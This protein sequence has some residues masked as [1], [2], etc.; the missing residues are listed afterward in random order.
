MHSTPIYKD[1]ILV[2][3]GHSHAL[4]LRMW[5]MNPIPGVRITLVSNTVLSPYSGMLPGVIAGHYTLDDN[6]IDLIKLCR[7][8]GARFIHGEVTGFDL[9]QQR[10]QLRGRPALSFDYAS[11]NTGAAPDQSVPGVA[12]FATPIKPIA[13]FTQRWQVLLDEFKA[14]KGKKHI[15]VV[16]SGAGG[17]EVLL[18][19]QHALSKDVD[20]KA[21]LHF[22]LVVRGQGLLKG[23]SR[24]VKNSVKN[25][26]AKCG[27]QVH[28][29]FD[30]AELQETQLVSNNGISLAVDS[31]FW[32]TSAVAPAWPKAC[33]FTTDEQG[34]ISVTPYLQSMSNKNIFAAGDIAHM[35]HAPRPKAGVYAV[36]QAPILLHNLRNAVLKKPL[37]SYKPQDDFLSLVALGNKTAAGSRK[38]LSFSGAW[39]WSWK[40]RIDREFM[41]KFHQLPPMSASKN[42][43]NLDIPNALIEGFADSPQHYQ[44]R[45]GGCGA[46]VGASVLSQ[47]LKDLHSVQQDGVLQSMGDDAA[48]FKVPEQQLLVQSVDQLR[49]FI[50]DP[51][52]F[53]RLS[54]L[55]ALS[56]LFAMSATPHSAQAMVTMPYA[57]ETIVERELAQLMAGAVEELNRHGCALIG[58][59]TSEGPEL[60]LG[61]TV[62]GLSSASDILNKAGAQAGDAL[63]LTQALGTGTLFAAN[64]RYL[65]KGQWIEQAIAAMLQSNQAAAKIFAQHGASA[66]TDVTGFGLAGHLAEIL[67]SSDSCAEI[68]LDKLPVMDGV[69]DCLERGIRSSLYPSN[70]KAERVI[71]NAHEDNCAGAVQL[72]K[73]YPS[74]FDPQTCGGLLASVPAEQAASSLSALHA[75]GYIEAVVIGEVLAEPPNEFG[76]CLYL[77]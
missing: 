19:M 31:V 74:L 58:G 75:A 60:S 9:K 55:H 66:C 52:T 23:Y 40:D 8:A 11:I 76:E 3:G 33:G 25:R 63:I 72:H 29:D 38:P 42:T 4:L 21:E 44:M 1:I 50:D 12:E 10:I 22:H 24:S 77:N 56:D 17:I 15:A 39:A 20:I 27:V 57:K 61:F 35:P 49:D 5:A 53:G 18:A 36:R 41:E 69:N 43:A 46:K 13:Q 51:Y 45:C 16:G 30:V 34:F 7:F 48:V 32:C 65:A 28:Y 59:H 6:H 62:N 67:K 64:M 68:A 2:G 54:A 71:F 70:R 14:S 26:L 47:V 73:H 37:K